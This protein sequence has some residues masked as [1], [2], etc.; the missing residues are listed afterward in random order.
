M[1]VLVVE[2]PTFDA[3]SADLRMRQDHGVTI[4]TPHLPARLAGGGFGSRV[5]HVIA[6]LLDFTRITEFKHLTG[7][8]HARTTIVYEFPRECGDPYYPVPRPENAERYK[9]YEALAAQTPH[10][11]FVGR[12]GIYRYYT[13]DQVVAQALKTWERLREA[14]CLTV[15]LP[16]PAA[17]GVKH[18]ELSD[19]GQALVRAATPDAGH[20][21]VAVLVGSDA[22]TQGS[23]GPSDGV[24]GDD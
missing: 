16:R 10:V 7:Q 1:P 2:E 6:D 11:Y 4:A 22:E 15:P 12:P 3:A 8:R 13:M 14:R 23:A 24:N 20:N 17:H 5:N 18:A 19:A 21:G 9:A